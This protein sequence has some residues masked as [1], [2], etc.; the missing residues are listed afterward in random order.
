M[1]PTVAIEN[2]IEGGNSRTSLKNAEHFVAK[3]RAEWVIRGSRMRFIRSVGPQRKQYG[4]RHIHTSDPG[5]LA[6]NFDYPVQAGLVQA[7]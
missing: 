2:P 5:S 6:G 1:K 7:K 3:G 4:P